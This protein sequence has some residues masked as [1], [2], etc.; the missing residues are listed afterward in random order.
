MVRRRAFLR[1]AG[2]FAS[3]VALAGCSGGQDGNDGE[4]NGS[5]DGDGEETDESDGSGND[6]TTATPESE[7][8][9]VDVGPE[10]RLRFEPEDV[11]IAVG[12]TVEWVARSQGHNVSSDPEASGKC[13]NPEGAEP[14]KSYEGDNHFAIME[15][16]ET[17]SHEFTVPGEYVYVCVPHEGQGMIGSVTVTE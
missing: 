9:Q 15:V 10:K 17:F 5:P 12:D 4:S 16:G 6:T 2:A 11:E 7:V 14:F 3:V 13:E 1:Q 8:V